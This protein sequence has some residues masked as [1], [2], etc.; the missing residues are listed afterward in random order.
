MSI[1]RQAA[2]ILLYV[3]QVQFR[4]I[5]KDDD[6]CK[7]AATVINAAAFKGLGIHQPLEK[8]DNKTIMQ[9]LYLRANKDLPIEL[10]NKLLLLVLRNK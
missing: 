6:D 1:A 7:F 3:D 10:N 4:A 9:C 2:S 8:L 5:V